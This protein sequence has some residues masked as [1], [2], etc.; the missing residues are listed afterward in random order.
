MQSQERLIEAVHGRRQILPDR[1]ID[2]QFLSEL[3]VDERLSQYRRFSQD[4]RALDRALRVAIFRSL[5]KSCG[6][7][8]R[9]GL[10]VDFLHPETFEIGQG[11]FIGANVYLQG[12]FDGRFQL[13]DRVWIGPGAYFD[14]RDLVVGD[15]VGWGP[16]AKVL[17]SEHTG[18]PAELPI[19]ATDLLIKPV[20][21]ESGADIGTGAILLPGVRIGEGA[22]VGAGAVVTR[23][24]PSRA[25]VAGCPAKVL[26]ER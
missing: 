10:G 15:D 24:V 5:T 18:Q 22:I 19:I 25:I 3:S 26:R 23:D 11:V 16:G 13:G 7:G 17:G 14:C 8:L 21:V 2:Q 6:D 4:D 1:C 9:L 20:V 12:R